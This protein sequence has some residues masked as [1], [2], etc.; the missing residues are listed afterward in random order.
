MCD[1]ELEEG[2]NGMDGLP[3]AGVDCV[4][5]SFCSVSLLAASFSDMGKTIPE[6]RVS[7]RTEKVY[8]EKD[9][10]GGLTPLMTS[11]VSFRLTGMIR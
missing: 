3:V 1:L 2:W 5:Y 8:E 9:P 7:R 4:I 10:G 11:C 6:A